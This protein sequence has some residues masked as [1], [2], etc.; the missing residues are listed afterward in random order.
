MTGRL[1]PAFWGGLFIGIL[2]ALPLV[3]TCCCLWVITGGVLAVWLAQSSQP[4]AV[5]MA[6]G[7]LLGVLSGLIGAV[8]AFPINLVFEDWERGWVLHVLENLD[9]NV[10][11]ELRDMMEASGRNPVMRVAGF[12][13]S[14]VLNSVFGMLGGMLGVA[15]FKKD[16]P[17][18]AGTVEVL[19][20]QA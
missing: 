8:I 3:K 4:S 17:P 1:Q 11:P 6:D 14:L 18:P 20:P 9:A 2:T 10:P 7:V 16:T 5:K 15:I 12:M 13:V 19:P